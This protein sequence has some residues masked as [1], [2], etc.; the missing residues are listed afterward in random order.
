MNNPKHVLE[1]KEKVYFCCD[2]C[3]VKFDLEPE[4]YVKAKS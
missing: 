3:M 4:K 1:S 2:G